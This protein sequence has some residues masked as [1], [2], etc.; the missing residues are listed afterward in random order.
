MEEV[1][2]T[3]A[4]APGKRFPQADQMPESTELQ[5]AVYSRVLDTL[6]QPRQTV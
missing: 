2:R 5:E 1:G 3:Q 6:V 4:A